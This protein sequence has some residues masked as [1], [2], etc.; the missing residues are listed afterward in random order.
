M[1]WNLADIEEARRNIVEGLNCNTC[2]H[3][4][5]PIGDCPYEPYHR[6]QR[7]LSCHKYSKQW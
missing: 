7:P 1:K 5:N 4:D 6:H 2:R 3:K